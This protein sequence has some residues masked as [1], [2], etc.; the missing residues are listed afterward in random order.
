MPQE[1]MN[2]FEGDKVKFP[3]PDADWQK[4]AESFAS[5]PGYKPK[6][7]IAAKDDRVLPKNFMPDE[8]KEE[9]YL[10]RAG[11]PLPAVLYRRE[12]REKIEL[13]AKI[14]V[15]YRQLIRASK[16]GYEGRENKDIRDKRAEDIQNFLMR[17]VFPG[18]NPEDRKKLQGGAWSVRSE[19]TQVEYERLIGMFRELEQGEDLGENKKEEITKE[20]PALISFRQVDVNKLKSRILD[21]GIEVTKIQQ[22]KIS[23]SQITPPTRPNFLEGRPLN[24]LQK[25]RLSIG[26]AIGRGESFDKVALEY[27]ELHEYM[28][29]YLTRRLAAIDLFERYERG[30]IQNMPEN[31]L[32]VASGPFAETEAQAAFTESYESLGLKLP[33]VTNLDT[34]KEMLMLGRSEVGDADAVKANMCRLPFK[35]K[36][37]DFAENTSLHLLLKK[38]T[39]ENGEALQALALAEMAR[40]IRE[41][42][43]IRIIY[44]EKPPEYLYGMLQQYGLELLTPQNS[45]FDVSGETKE[46]FA[47]MVP[48]KEG[49]LLAERAA[50]KASQDFYILARKIKD[51]IGIATE[52]AGINTMTTAPKPK[53]ERVDWKR[54]GFGLRAEDLHKELRHREKEFE[55]VTKNDDMNEAK[56][57]FWEFGRAGREANI[58]SGDV[59]IENAEALPTSILLKRAGSR[60][61]KNTLEALRRKIWPKKP[62][63]KRISKSYV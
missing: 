12:T 27:A 57:L 10:R 28:H 34:S 36:S 13:P 60:K 23:S 6:I 19:T 16:V 39:K 61:F 46:I 25:L 30:E 21:T 20:P 53:G 41:N 55:S 29:W 48:G 38:A 7:T 22:E 3:P 44:I 63:D 9:E 58:A 33:S 40:V 47:D 52:Q 59:D 54:V 5:E 42:G 24:R 49:R 45:R 18:L 43:L 14:G 37:F 32:S 51:G 15:I 2:N 1:Q 11:K 50:A 4:I 56:N 62:K 8:G 17:S 26:R 31:I 35:E